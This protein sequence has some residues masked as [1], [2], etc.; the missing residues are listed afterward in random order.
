MI[1]FVGTA[2]VQSCLIL[3]S[4]L[5]VDHEK[6]VR[7]DI[8]DTASEPFEHST[9]HALSQIPSPR[10]STGGGNLPCHHLLS[11]VLLYI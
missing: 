7:T 8:P 5:F 9:N 10:L 1:S 4:L 2:E 6:F 11:V 3:H